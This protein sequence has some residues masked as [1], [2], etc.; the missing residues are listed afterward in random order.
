MKNYVN[1]SSVG[2][3]I[4]IAL[5]CTDADVTMQQNCLGSQSTRT[6]WCG[7]SSTNSFIQK[8]SANPVFNVSDKINIS[9][10]SFINSAHLCGGDATLD[11]VCS[12]KSDCCNALRV[13]DKLSTSPELRWPSISNSLIV[14]AIFMEPVELFSNGQSIRNT[15]SIVWAWDSGMETGSQSGG[16]TYINYNDGR[17]VVDSKVTQLPPEPLEIGRMYTWCVWAWNDE[18]T[19]IVKSSAA[20]PFIAEGLSLNKSDIGLINGDWQLTTAVRK[21]DSQNITSTF[22]LAH[23][24]INLTCEGGTCVINKSKSMG[25][26]LR[27]DEYIDFAEPEFGI[28]HLELRWLCQNSISAATNYNGAEV[29]VLFKR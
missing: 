24:S 25:I 15:N 22:P 20:I 5:S 16:V 7:T 26:A 21:I 4:L 2:L 27:E 9:P 11:S 10:Y 14:A 18:G 6:N 19:Q 28:E 17:K 29:Q 8:A 1:S 13:I 23:I 12:L 3:L